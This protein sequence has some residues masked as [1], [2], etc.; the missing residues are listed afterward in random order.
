M[1]SKSIAGPGA[2][3]A[4]TEPAQERQEPKH[5]YAQAIA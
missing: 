1:A 3:A 5:K 2:G 4:P